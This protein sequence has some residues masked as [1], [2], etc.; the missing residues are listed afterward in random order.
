MIDLYVEL[1]ILPFKEHMMW[2]YS[3][4]GINIE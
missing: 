4:G 1:L 3:S 2:Q